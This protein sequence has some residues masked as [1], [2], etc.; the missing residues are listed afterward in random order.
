M[1]RVYAAVLGIGSPVE[2]DTDAVP[3]A[4]PEWGGKVRIVTRHSADLI[5]HS[6]RGRRTLFSMLVKNKH[7]ATSDT[8]SDP[9][10]D[11]LDFSQVQPGAKVFSADLS[12][13]TDFLGWPI[14]KMIC[15]KAQID[16]RWVSPT[17]LSGKP[18]CRGTAMGLPSSWPVLSLAHYAV[19]A[20]VDP[21]HAF[22]IKGDDLIALWPQVYIDRYYRLCAWVGFVP[23][24]KKTVVSDRYGM[25]CEVTYF[26]TEN[27]LSRMKDFSIRSFVKGEPLDHISWLKIHRRGVPLTRLSSMFTRFFRHWIYLSKLMKVPRYLPQACGGLGFPPRR[28]HQ[29]M[30]WAEARAVGRCHNGIP[31]RVNDDRAGSTTKMFL[32]VLDSVIFSVEGRDVLTEK[33]RSKSALVLA[34]AAFIDAVHGEYI[35]TEHSRRITVQRLSTLF[36]AISGPGRPVPGTTYATAYDVADRL[37]VVP[38]MAP[39][40]AKI[41]PTAFAVG[42]SSTGVV[43]LLAP[44]QLY[45]QLD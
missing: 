25:F 23:N 9:D 38:K 39:V 4:I 28:M 21:G 22:K 30:S 13:A 42:P 29:K 18:V 3:L 27:K 20:V 41:S 37:R 32:K 45:V 19:C 6:H 10:L 31:N 36:R 44:N 11:V 7:C 16:F 33:F 35:R 2:Y 43:V 26:R 5:A 1:T 34:R 24:K 14:I 15:Q 40:L 12:A 8:L 17:T